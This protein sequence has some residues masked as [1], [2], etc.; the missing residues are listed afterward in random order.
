MEP[1]E[2][3]KR[4]ES[5][6]HLVELLNI[7]NDYNEGRNEWKNLFHISQGE[8]LYNHDPQVDLEINLYT[9]K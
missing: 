1:M 2:L 7:L 4:E 6:G 3:L 8:N 5:I 9:V